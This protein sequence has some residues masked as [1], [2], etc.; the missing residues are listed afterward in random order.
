MEAS[1]I[2][3]K[4]WI[5]YMAPYCAQNPGQILCI[6][7]CN[8]ILIKFVYHSRSG[9]GRSGPISKDAEAATVSCIME[10]HAL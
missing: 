2:K 4:L 1:C 8:F 3:S 6:M 5:L 7:L 10:R 9:D